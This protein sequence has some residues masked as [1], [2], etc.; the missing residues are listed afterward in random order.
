MASLD[1]KNPVGDGMSDESVSPEF[2][3][4]DDK[5]EELSKTDDMFLNFTSRAA[6]IE[7]DVQGNMF[8]QIMGYTFHPES[9]FR[10]LWDCVMISL[11]CLSSMWEPYKAAFVIFSDTMAWWEYCVDGFYW[12]DIFLTFWTAIYDNGYQ[13]V[14]E[15]NRIAEIYFRFWFWIDFMATFPW[16]NAADFLFEDLHG[17]AG[18]R[19]VKMIRVMRLAKAARIIQRLTANWT[20]HT[21]YIETLK[22]FI[23]SSVCA[24]VLACLFWILPTLVDHHPLA[25]KT[26]WRLSNSLTSCADYSKEGCTATAFELEDRMCRKPSWYDD[27]YARVVSE[28]GEMRQPDDDEAQELCLLKKPNGVDPFCPKFCDLPPPG[29]T[30]LIQYWYTFY[31]AVTTMTTI[32]YG[33]I[34]PARAIEVQFI[35]IAMVVGVAFFALFVQQIGALNEVSGG[36]ESETA[37]VKNDVV[38]F[39]R[40]HNVDQVLIR[41]VVQFINFKSSSHA[42][43]SFNEADERLGVL[44][45]PLMRELRITMFLDIVKKVKMFGWNTVQIDDKA[46][47]ALFDEIDEDGGGSLDKDELKQLIMSLGQSATDEDMDKLMIEMDTSQNEVIEF[48]EFRT[49]WKRKEAEVHSIPQAP[50]ELMR[51]LAC[52]VHTVATAPDDIIFN[53]G[54]YGRSLYVVLTGVVQIQEIGAA[55]VKPIRA[56]HGDDPEP[57]FGLSAILDNSDHLLIHDSSQKRFSDWVVVAEQYSNLAFITRK[58]LREAVQAIWPSG[59]EGMREL[60]LS[61][62]T[63]KQSAKRA[64]GLSRQASIDAEIDVQKHLQTRY[65]LKADDSEPS[66]KDVYESMQ[67]QFKNLENLVEN[68]LK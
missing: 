5:N 36:E 65:G 33:D 7:D 60:A 3:E 59:I 1:F 12:L 61:E 67:E 56:V 52:L 17:S 6:T 35:M 23:Y 50:A 27:E 18:L 22:F 63:D 38:A 20:I 2:P 43:H 64:E 26:D 16:D 66:V 58:D 15:K 21:T 40:E 57:T 32:G 55:E 30:E 37:R 24:H 48:K 68:L 8:Q 53:R 31:W 10:K 25:E 9:K 19:L 34:T 44:S 47:R 46:L 4:T 45:G 41:K 49:W 54:E 42:A 39:M 29:K 14:T 13:L 62:Y 11:V 28:G 51:T